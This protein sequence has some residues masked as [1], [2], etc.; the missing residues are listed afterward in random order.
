MQP[1]LD[2]LEEKRPATRR[3]IRVHQTGDEPARVDDAAA[4]VFLLGDPLRELYPACYA[5]AA[6]LASRARSAGVRVL[7]APES[8]SNAVKSVQSKRWLSAGITTPEYRR[9]E[10]YDEMIATVMEV[11]GPDPWN[12]PE[13][14]RRAAEDGRPA[15]EALAG[16]REGSLG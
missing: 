6:E 4:I 14:F 10:S 7:N 9:F 1:A 15:P 16:G 13:D 2:Y 8:L 12:D 5:E 3:R 11:Y